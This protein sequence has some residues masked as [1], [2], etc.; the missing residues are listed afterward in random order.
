MNR[1]YTFILAGTLCLNAEAFEQSV[2]CLNQLSIKVFSKDKTRT[3]SLFETFNLSN[4]KTIV[5]G[6]LEVKNSS[7]TPKKFSTKMLEARFNES[8][9]SRSY[10]KGVGTFVLDFEGGQEIAPNSTLKIDVVWYPNLKAGIK[11]DSAEFA[12]Y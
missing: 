10:V 6:K 4:N 11:L 5:A 12:C 7:E 3:F 1:I 9:A 2:N 8:E